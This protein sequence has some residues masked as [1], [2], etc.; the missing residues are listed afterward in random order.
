MITRER[1]AVL[2]SKRKKVLLENMEVP[3]DYEG[4]KLVVTLR[5]PNQDN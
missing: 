2:T 1:V 3:V 5:D 4:P